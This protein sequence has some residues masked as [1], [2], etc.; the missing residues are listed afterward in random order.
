MEAKVV[1]VTSQGFQPVV[2]VAF[3]EGKD[4]VHTKRYYL[5]PGQ[6]VDDIK[7][8]IKDDFDRAVKMVEDRTK[9]EE[10]KNQKI[11]LSGV[12]GA[13]Q[14]KREKEEA[15]AVEADPDQAE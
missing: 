7:P 10:L 5:D 4:T 14:I 3:V 6:T 15:E 12:K 1:S 8:Q 13:E 2:E 11:D 9:A